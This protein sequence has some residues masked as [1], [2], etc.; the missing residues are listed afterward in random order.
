[1]YKEYRLDEECEWIHAD[2]S[3]KTGGGMI[4]DHH[5]HDYYELLYY[6]KGS[7]IQTSDHQTMTL[8]EGDFIVLEPK[9]V[10]STYAITDTCEII[11]LLFFS[12]SNEEFTLANQVLQTPYFYQSELKELSET[13][14]SEYQRKERCYRSVMKGCLHQLAGYLNRSMNTEE[15]K[16]EPAFIRMRE[17]FQH[18]EKNGRQEIT[19]LEAAQQIGYSPD[20]LTRLCK[21]YAGCSFKHYMDKL[22]MSMAVRMIVFDHKKISETADALGYRDV[23]SFSRAFKRLYGYSPSAL[24]SRQQES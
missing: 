13:M 1:M 2:I 18:I 14:Y 7:A 4:V 6:Q 17:L 11:T 23:T 3:R 8:R 10:H 20:H 12:G 19:L 21:K 24:V 22:K 5:W 15:I 16:V 9:T